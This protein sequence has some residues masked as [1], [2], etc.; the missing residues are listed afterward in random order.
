MKNTK[1]RDLFVGISVAPKDP[2]KKRD[3]VEQMV[4]IQIAMWVGEK[5]SYCGHKYK[6][7]E[8]FKERLVKKGYGKDGFVCSL[9][10]GDYEKSKKAT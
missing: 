2:I 5:C 7:V 3:W 6:S 4:R 10:W 1:D 8:D 9:C